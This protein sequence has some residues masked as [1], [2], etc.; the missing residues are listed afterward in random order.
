MQHNLEHDVER[1]DGELSTAGVLPSKMEHASNPST[2]NSWFAHRWR[3]ILHWFQSN[4]FSP[5]FLTSPW[6]HPVFGYLFAVLGQV[7]AVVLIALLIQAF[8]DFRFPETL[9]LLVVLLAAL[10]W[11]VGPSVVA[12]L[13]GGILLILLILP[14]YFSLAVTRVEDATGVTLYT[15]VGLI[16]S[17]LA[18]QV[19]RAH[20]RAQTLSARLETIIEA[21]PDSLVIFD[22]QGVGM[23]WNPAA[24]KIGTIETPNIPLPDM[25]EQLDLRNLQG[26]KLNL[27][28]LPLARALRGEIV[29]NGEM[30]YKMP[31]ERRDRFV[32]I[33]AAP[34]RDP[35]YGTI[36][37]AVTITRDV[38][39]RRSNEQRTRAALDALLEI[40]QALVQEPPQADWS[41]SQAAFAESTIARRLAEMTR[42]VL[43]CQRLAFLAVEPKTERIYP[44][45][46]VGLS[47]ELEQQWWAEQQ[48]QESHFGDGLDSTAVAQLRA[49]QALLLDLTQPPWCDQP[50]PYGIR[51]MLLAAMRTAD[52][53]VGLITL[54]YGGAEHEYTPDEIRLTITVGRL[55]ALVIERHRLLRE[56]EEVRAS[57]MALQVANERMDTF[58]G[59]AGHELKTP[60]TSIKGNLQL[61]IRRL[62]NIMKEGSGEGVVARSSKLEALPSMLDR[63]ERHVN[64]LIRLVRDLVEVSRIQTGK[65]ELQMAP[66]NLADIVDEV[67][68]DYRDN[69]PDRVIQLNHAEGP[70][71][72]IIADAVRVSQVVS[73]YLSNALKYSEADRPVEV[74]LEILASQARVSVRDEGT[75][76][77]R[78]QQEHIWE[79]FYRV[80]GVE[81][82]SGSGVGL[83]LG[84]HICRTVI[85]EQG[86]QVGVESSPGEGST[87]WFTLPLAV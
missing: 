14:P 12:T 32:S 61:V 67:V 77:S 75:G 6:S 55:A 78:E 72:P 46:V 9:V 87:F 36:E 10:G 58:I 44:L 27:E 40:A 71:V 85:E 49:D 51:T 26:D 47:P 25:P 53:V 43:G 1:A 22:R 68:A 64:I 60:L 24:R 56:R 54:D 28:E 70:V 4:T 33:S 63:A 66:S 8:P 39:E 2:G 21:I 3:V 73:N 83:G 17:I 19:Q 48:R 42:Q 84:L 15:C 59:I 82:Q 29:R 74:R 65:L 7:V 37:G 18:S 69:V 76:L 80:P 13:V 79:L 30:V 31:V 35:R 50:N 38:T 23:Q 16:I 86:G 11:G 52:Q 62:N 20:Y 81:V 34:L 5:D 57:V 41:E 45:A